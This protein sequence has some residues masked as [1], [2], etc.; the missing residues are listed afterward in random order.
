MNRYL[1]IIMISLFGLFSVNHIFTFSFYIPI[2]TYLSLKNRKY[3]YLMFPLSFLGMYLFHFTFYLPY[4]LFY[5]S[6]FLFTLL[7]RKNHLIA[8]LLYDVAM[9][10]MTTFLLENINFFY[11]FLSTFICIL[12]SLF[13]L[14]CDDKRSIYSMAMLEMLISLVLTLS[15]IQIKIEQIPLGFYLGLY[16]SMYLSSKKQTLMSLLFSFILFFIFTYF[17]ITSYG[18]FFPMVCFIYLL[19]K[20]YSRFIPLFMIAIGYFFYPTLFPISFF[21]SLL[22][23]LVIFEITRP[24]M[25]QTVEEKKEM[26]QI[27]LQAYHQVEQELN[28]FALFLDKISNQFNKK[29]DHQLHNHIEELMNSFCFRCPSKMD[30]FKRNKSKLYFYFKSLFG[31]HIHEEI[32]CLYFEEMKAK[33][34]YLLSRTTAEKNTSDIPKFTQSISYILRQYNVDH[35]QRE[36]IEYHQCIE[37]KKR[38]VQYGYSISYFQVE[39]IF[40][41]DFQIDVGLYGIDFEKEKENLYELCRIF[42]FPISLVYKEQKKNKTYF[43]ILPKV[44]YDVRYGYGS[45]ALPGN[46]ICGDNYLVKLQENSKVLAM[47]SDG[48]GKGAQAGIESARTLHLLDEITKSQMSPETSLQIL[49]TFYYLQDENERYSTLDFL[50]INR[51]NGEAFLYKA[52]ATTTFIMHED[53]SCDRFENEQLPFGFNEFIVSKKLQLKE[54]DLIIMASDGVFENMENEDELEE[55]IR[56]IRMMEPQKITYEILNYVR[57]HKSIHSDDMSVITLKM[58]LAM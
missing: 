55:Y 19:P 36:E 23:L 26:N 28:S 53:G 30:C 56:G 18:F 33:A 43:S 6:L 46:Q 14:I 48:M 2:V 8:I 31:E 37:L 11:F 32:H 10:I 15:T 54:N 49:N 21:I 12:W 17:H 39:K 57:Y 38:F 5:G 35:Y 29:E 1:Y 51:F 3:L 41:T 42:P 25:I 16:F 52:G 45:I 24:I 34:E 20:L 7:L 9:H 4:A 47:I 13:I 58:I 22:I 50:E 27:Y 44:S 40:L